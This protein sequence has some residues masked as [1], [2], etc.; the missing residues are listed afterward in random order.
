[1][2]KDKRFARIPQTKIGRCLGRPESNARI[3]KNLLCARYRRVS[4]KG[5][6]V[7]ANGLQFI[8]PGIGDGRLA[9][10]G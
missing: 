4:S 6:S 1:M 9:A 7:N 5:T 8:A 2:P 3:A 10:V